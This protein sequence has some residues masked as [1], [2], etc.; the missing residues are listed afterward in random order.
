MERKLSYKDEEYY[1]EYSLAYFLDSM[2]EDKYDDYDI[3]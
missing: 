3:Q 2:I 1:K